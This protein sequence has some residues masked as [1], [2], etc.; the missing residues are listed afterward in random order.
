MPANS[1]WGRAVRRC[2]VTRWTLE[3]K[4]E[5]LMRQ[6]EEKLVV[7]V[8]RDNASTSTSTS[9]R[10][11]SIFCVSA[12]KETNVCAVPLWPA[13]TQ[14]SHGN[15]RETLRLS[16][17]LCSSHWCEHPCA[18][19]Y[20]SLVWTGILVLTLASHVWTTLRRDVLIFLLDQPQPRETPR[21]E[22]SHSVNFSV[23]YS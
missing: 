1:L 23:C 12:D 4:F 9:K 19:A 14:D 6:I 21:G 18:Y 7:S 17:C 11:G 22:L 10:N 3:T 20:I 15:W 5:F 16:L 8:N 13:V 2:D